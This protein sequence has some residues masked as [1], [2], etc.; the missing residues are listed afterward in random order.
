M[1]DIP[2]L[3][4]MVCSQLDQAT[5]AK[6]ARVCKKW[7]TIVIPHVWRTIPVPNNPQCP[8]SSGWIKFRQHILDDYLY[9]E[10]PLEWQRLQAQ[11]PPPKRPRGRPR[12][13]QPPVQAQRTEGNFVLAKYGLYV[14]QVECFVK[15]CNSLQVH[16]C[17]PSK[18]LDANPSTNDLV[19]QLLKRCPNFLIHFEMSADYFKGADLFDFALKLMP[20]VQTLTIAGIGEY[21]QGPSWHSQFQKV[22]AAASRHLYSLTISIPKQQGHFSLGTNDMAPALVK[23]PEIT[24]RPTKL[25]LH[26]FHWRYNKDAPSEDWS[27]LWRVCGQV[28]EIYVWGI[29]EDL[30]LD[31]T[32]GMRVWMPRLD[33]AKFG[34]TSAIPDIDDGKISSI[35]AAGTKGWSAVHFYTTAQ[36]GPRTFDTLLQ[37]ASTLK[38]LSV[39]RVEDPT[40]IIRVL[41]SCPELRKLVTIAN[42]W[43]GGG[44]YPQVAAT[45]FI[46]WD[47]ETRALR[48]WPCATKLERLAVQ[49]TGVPQLKPQAADKQLTDVRHYF[50]IQRRVCERLGQFTNLRVLQLGWS[51]QGIQCRNFSWDTARN[52]AAL[53]Q[54]TCVNLTLETGLDKLSG[55]KRLED[56]HIINMDHQ[57]MEE[58]VVWMAEQWPR[59]SK[60]YGLGAHTAAHNWLLMNRRKIDLWPKSLR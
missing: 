39:V 49:V 45:E 52:T 43:R 47:P 15:L 4:E 26:S 37:H 9:Q 10:R 25:K 1:L 41:R 57:V 30:A 60:L 28:E 11:L 36:V 33:T 50:E 3:D 21:H 44:P 6:C 7:N 12:N 46:D 29:S 51:P 35:L 53:K 20:S 18:S 55:L 17:D 13:N 22:L 34:R 42:G 24:A 48:P 23:K 19:L 54:F 32:K 5:L 58:E 59:L 8:P 14:R 31:L 40:G 27:W 2:E 16:P 56:L 38:E